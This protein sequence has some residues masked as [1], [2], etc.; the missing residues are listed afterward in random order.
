MSGQRIGQ[1]FQQ[2]AGHLVDVA[3]DC[4]DIGEPVDVFPGRPEFAEDVE[5]RFAHLDRDVRIARQT[6]PRDAQEFFGPLKSGLIYKFDCR[7]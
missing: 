6:R 7:L 4:D 5:A 3:L 2:V 1:V